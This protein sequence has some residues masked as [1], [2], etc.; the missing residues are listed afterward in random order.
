MLSISRMQPPRLSVIIASWNTGDFLAGCL[1]S[2]DEQEV[3]GGFETIVV[4]NG[5]TDGTAELLRSRGERVR[6]ISNSDNVGFSAAN[7]QAAEIARGATLFFLNSDTRLLA[8]DT[9]ERI[10]TAVEAPGVAIAG[11]MLVNPDGSLQPSC[12][13]HPSVGRALVVGAGLHRLL[14]D[15][16][17]ERIAP[18]TWSHDRP[19]D[20]DWVK[21][22]A[23]AVRA[24]LFRELGGFW[25]TL[26]G[27]ET[28]LAY[29]AKERGLRVRFEPSARVMHYGNQ[30]NSQRYGDAGRAARVAHA[31]LLFL[32]SHYPRPR[33]AA[34]RAITGCAY[35]LRAVAH[36]LLRH[37]AQAR[38]YRA[39]ARTYAAGRRS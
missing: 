7:N 25:P 31:E 4:D 10:A 2:L 11:P 23:I 30:A 29:K 27:E 17:R 21:G 35:A 34:V 8:P 15:G 20:T 37:G 14:P 33:A 36:A 1:D 28:D 12:A 9:L 3:A 38:V 39:L 5:S 32:R 18:D 24:D 22:A 6:T 13:A 26:Y 16:L 19:S